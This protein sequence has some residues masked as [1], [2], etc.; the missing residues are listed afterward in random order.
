MSG[1]SARRVAL[2]VIRRVTEDDAYSN[3]ALRAA[4]D[5]SGLDGRDRALAT[6]LTYGTLR[7]LVALDEELATFLSRPVASTPR[8]AL[9][10]LRLGLQQLRSTRIPPH[11][12][13]SESVAISEPRYRG[14]V[15]AVLRRASSSPAPSLAGDDDASVARR[16]GLAPWAVAELR[17]LRPDDVAA[18]A[19]GFAEPAALTLRVDRCRADIDEVADAI[20]GTGARVERGALHAGSL[21]VRDLDGSPATLPGYAEGWFATQDQASSLVAEALEVHPGDRVA[22]VCAA[23]G[24]KAVLLACGAGP[25]GLVVAGDVSPQRARLVAAAAERL[26]H[27]V[28]TIVADA[29]RPALRETSFDRVLVDAPCSGIG[30]A[31]RRPE[32]LWRADA[33]APTRIAELQL[34]IVRHAAAL[35]APGG[36]LVYSVCTFPTAETDAVCDVLLETAPFLEPAAVAGPD[37][38][39]ERIR[40]WPHLHGCD[41]MFLAAFRRRADG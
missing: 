23:P 37:G 18:A 22:D 39:A 25:D 14:L 31:R 15:N 30:S 8:A 35:L 34:E 33:D 6:E 9:A 41:A 11:A 27:V 3:L 7:R 28:R 32:L 19:M 40:L 29:R 13:V 17:R 21:V 2:A 4:L 12:A 5:R 38:A 1:T 24:G 26:G 16:S 36:R 20:G 10:V